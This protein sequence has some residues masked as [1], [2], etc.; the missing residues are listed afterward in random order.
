MPCGGSADNP[1]GSLLIS[2]TLETI[3]GVG[4]VLGSA[5]PSYVWT[6]CPTISFIGAMRFDIDDIATM[7]EDGTF[8]GV[9][10]HEMGHV[11]GVGQ[12]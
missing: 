12:V 10:L 7:E 6:A 11:I 9:I 3:D 2:S 4:N 5:G 8:E 1:A